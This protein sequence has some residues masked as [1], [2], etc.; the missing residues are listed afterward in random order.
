MPPRGQ[1]PKPYVLK[2]AEGFRGHRKH[3]QGVDVPADSF[4]PPFELGKVAR[5]E[6]DRVIG[7][8]F[9]I[10]SSDAAALADRCACFQR[11]QE[12]EQEIDSEGMTVVTEKG[13]QTHPA[14]RNAKTYRTSLQRY[15][16][17][18]G[19]TASSRTRVGS[20]AK[21]EVDAIEAKLCG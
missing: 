4:D 14:V 1:K 12:C 2:A 10:R 13:V 7:V 21:R 3:A 6:W 5:A 20:D 17:E 11:L 18:L 15:D 19:L 8:A 9:W 16:S